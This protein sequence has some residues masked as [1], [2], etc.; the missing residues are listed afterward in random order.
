MKEIENI[1]F[2]FKSK[3]N[4][5]KFGLPEENQT[6]L[7]LIYISIARFVIFKLQLLCFLHHSSHFFAQYL[8][9]YFSLHSSQIQNSFILFTIYS[10]LALYLFINNEF[11]T[12][13]TE[14]NAIAAAAIIGFNKKPK[15]G[16]K[17]PAAI[18]I[19]AVL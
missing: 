16:Y 11:K 4:N 8:S 18:G 10:I 14:L 15:S 1:T 12:T 13:E 3:Q 7:E 19:A 9:L 17:I 6:L 5:Y 2:L